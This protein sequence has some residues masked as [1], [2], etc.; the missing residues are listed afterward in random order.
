MLAGNNLNK[1]YGRRIALQNVDVS[2]LPG[3][4]TLLVGPSGINKSA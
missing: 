4:A 3:R 2:V 1:A